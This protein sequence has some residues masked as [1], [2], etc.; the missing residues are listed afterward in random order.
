LKKSIILQVQ[1]VICGAGVYQVFMLLFG[2]V[3]E[4]CVSCGWYLLHV[5]IVTDWIL[6]LA[7]QSFSEGELKDFVA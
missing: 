7:F 5:Y 1:V 3:Q 4:S 2:K 6:M